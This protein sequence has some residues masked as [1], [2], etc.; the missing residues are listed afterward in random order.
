MPQ[1]KVFV[2]TRPERHIRNAINRYR[3]HE[4]FCL[5]DIEESVVAVDIRRYLDFRLSA[6]EIQRAFPELPPPPWQPTEKQ[7][8]ILT[9]MS[10]KLFIIASTAAAFILDGRRLDPAQQLS[11][12]IDGVSLRTFLGSK[13]TTTLDHVYMQII[14]AAQPDPVDDWVEWFQ[15]V[16]GTITL[17]Q[18]PLPCVGLAGLLDID[19]T[20]VIRTLSNL[21]SL[22]APR[23]Q[24]QVFRVHHKSFPDFISDRHRCRIGPE[25]YIDR[26]IHHLRIAKRCLSIMNEYLHPNLCGLKPSEWYKERSQLSDRI[27]ELMVVQA[28]MI[29]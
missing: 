20:E 27:Q 7:K 23:G 3:N 19:A 11:K 1:L 16:V 13:H 6:I 2:T 5:H 26:R 21:Y 25:F 9:G 15:V 22:L 8:K 18:D 14:R 4:Q 17:L 28:S 24:D 29:N 10:G 12:L